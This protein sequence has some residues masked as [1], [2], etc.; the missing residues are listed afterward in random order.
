M[1]EEERRRELAASI[2]KLTRQRLTYA[3]AAARKQRK[4]E[5]KRAKTQKKAAAKA[6]REAAAKI[7][8]EKQI[9]LDFNIKLDQPLGMVSRYLP[10]YS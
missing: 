4:Q 3:D 9:I 5:L 6:A 7:E 10:Q 1:L 8:A 2:K